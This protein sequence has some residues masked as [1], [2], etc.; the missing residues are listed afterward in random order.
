[1]VKQ[2]LKIGSRSIGNRR[3]ESVMV[4][5][6]VYAQLDRAVIDCIRL[7]LNQSQP[8]GNARF[9]AKTKTATGRGSV[10]QGREAGRGMMRLMTSK[11]C[12]AGSARSVNTSRL[13]L[14]R[15]PAAALASASRRISLYRWVRTDARISRNTYLASG[16]FILARAASPN[17]S[18]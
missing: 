15:R 14:F 18:P 13:H 7:V 8:L 11:E 10:K 16:S 12:R 17:V 9:Y 4:R 5:S 6:L 2:Y 3:Q 1:V